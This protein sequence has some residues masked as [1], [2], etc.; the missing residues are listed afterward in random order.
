MTAKKPG[1]IVHRVRAEHGS[2]TY[3][4]IATQVNLCVLTVSTQYLAQELL[5]IRPHISIQRNH[6][7]GLFRRVQEMSEEVAVNMPSL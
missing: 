2:A 6:Q 7:Q 4:K 3:A 5:T 1:N